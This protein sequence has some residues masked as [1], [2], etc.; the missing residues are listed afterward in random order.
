[1]TALDQ[2]L[3]HYHQWAKSQQTPAPSFKAWI[4]SDLKKD[5]IH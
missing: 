2:F 5:K 1:M 4:E 3:R